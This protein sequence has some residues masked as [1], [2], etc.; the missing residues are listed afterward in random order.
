[1]AD[2]TKFFQAEELVGGRFKLASLMQKRIVEL[3]QG[4]V[5]LVET[6]SIRLSEIALDEILDGKIHLVPASELEE[7]L[8]DVA[9]AA[10]GSGEVVTAATTK[11]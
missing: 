10:D 2:Y 7:E 3:M 9:L 8:S 1:M 4:A 5:P 11:K 6:S